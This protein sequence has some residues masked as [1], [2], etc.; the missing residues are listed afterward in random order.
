MDR[1]TNMA[2]LKWLVEWTPTS[3]HHQESF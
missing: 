1:H 3:T 2:R